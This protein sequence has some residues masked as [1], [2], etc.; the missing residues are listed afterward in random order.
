M[1]RYSSDGAP[2]IYSY[3]NARIFGERQVLWLELTTTSAN[4]VDVAGA[5]DGLLTQ[6]VQTDRY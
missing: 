4:A 3:P 2:F 6:R 5:L 1:K